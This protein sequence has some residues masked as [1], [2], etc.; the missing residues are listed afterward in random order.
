M[1]VI[2]TAALLAGCGSGGPVSADVSNRLAAAE[3]AFEH[4]K[5]DE[6]RHDE[7]GVSYWAAIGKH[8]LITAKDEANDTHSSSGFSSLASNVLGFLEG[9]PGLDG[10]AILSFLLYLL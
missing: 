10:G 1:A 5:A 4:V 7:P 6:K 3:V 2:V 8:D 9:N